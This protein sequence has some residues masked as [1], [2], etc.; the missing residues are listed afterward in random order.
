MIRILAKWLI[1]ALAVLVAARY[2]PGIEVGSFYAAA[3]VALALSLVNLVLRPI[4]I[5][6]TLPLNLLTLGL[7][8]F[9]VNAA[10]FWLVSTFVKGFEVEGFVAALLGSLVVSVVSALGGMLLKA[11]DDD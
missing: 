8:T 6:L 1:V 10:L 4:V 11:R 9:V 7:F 3:V 2:V 5:L